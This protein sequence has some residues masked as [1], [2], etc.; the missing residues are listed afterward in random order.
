MEFTGERFV[1]SLNEPEISYEHWHRYLYASS[2]VKDKVVLDIASGEGYGSFL[3][4]SSN[5]KAVWGVDIDPEAV[6]NAGQNYKNDNLEYLNGSI[7]AI[8]VETE[9]ID[10]LISFETIEH[11]GEA[12]QILFL[13]EIERVLKPDGILIISTPN[14]LTYSDIPK[15]N[16]EFHIKEFYINEFLDFL[17]PKFKYIELLGQ[18][19]FTNS[20]IWPQ[21]N[22]NQT[23]REYNIKPA[24]SGFKVSKNTDKEMLY[25]VTVC[26]NTRPVEVYSSILVDKEDLIMKHKDNLIKQ[27]DQALDLKDRHISLKNTE[28][29]KK[30][31]EYSKLN[32]YLLDSQDHI[33]KLEERLRNRSVKHWLAKIRF[34]LKY[35]SKGSYSVFKSAMSDPSSLM[36]N[37]RKLRQMGITGLLE[38]I[39][40]AQSAKAPLRLKTV[41]EFKPLNS[42]PKISVVMPVYNVDVKWLDTA[43]DSVLNQ[44]YENF[45]LVI[46]DDGSQK[47]E[48]LAYLKQIDHEKI[49]VQLN[50]KNRGISRASNDGARLATGDYIALLDNDDELRQNALYEVAKAINEYDPDVIYSD[51]ARVDIHGNKKSPFLKPDWS[52]DLLRSQ[53]YICH[54]LVFKKTLFETVGGFNSEFDGSQDYDLMLRFSEHTSNIYHI[55]EIL[56]FWREIESS[57]AMNPD[58]KP[59]SHPA[60]LV[61]LDQHLKRAFG[62]DAHA[63]KTEFRLVY[64]ARYPLARDISASII[65]PTKDRCDLLSDCVESI[66]KK[67]EG[68][69]YEI[70]IMNNDSKDP[71][72][73]DWFKTITARHSNIRIIDA[74]YPFNWSRINNH[75]AQH[76]NGEVLVFL[77]NDTRVIHPGW[78]TRLCENAVRP[79]VGV[80]GGLLLYEDDTVQHAGVVVGMG[81]WADHVFKAA[82]PRHFIHPFVSPMM[83]RNVSSVTGACLGIS[84][85]VFDEVNGFNEEFIICGSDV[86]IALKT[87]KKGYLNVYNPRINLYHLESKSRT[88][89]IPEKDFEMSE[90][91]Y[92][93]L[94]KTGDPYYN[95][96]LSLESL[97]PRLKNKSL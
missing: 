24:D 72:T 21:S 26:S 75:G 83:A 41:F 46:V 95:K 77:N 96:N 51:E 1:S 25:A 35:V 84:R 69:C 90:R 34:I 67:T 22:T 93:D 63:R 85:Q 32:Q 19:I 82:E 76:A 38:N 5:A 2:F 45:E 40:Y 66:L 8:P 11:V 31:E 61:A 80:V 6:R 23:F 4:S 91:A 28:L 56:Y 29:K 54:L 52:P 33:S 10:V 58:S 86:E 20:Y 55:P 97:I 78:L 68:P 14:K 94:K 60:G 64:D 59:V 30:D 12:D 70:I 81:G 71:K 50:E 88:S 7:A 18:K 87:L 16:N 53:M 79:D 39:R 36:R 89:Y 3:L 13:G 57:T 73:R 42:Y 62:Q 43:V 27:Q 48:T 37:I 44:V 15:Y 49:V 74:A 65:I 9:S 17:S 47:A 92:A